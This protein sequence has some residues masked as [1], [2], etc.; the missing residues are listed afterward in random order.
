LNPIS[1]REEHGRQ[2]NQACK[3]EQ[4]EQT[5]SCMDNGKDEPPGDHASETEALAEDE[6]KIVVESREW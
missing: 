5:G 3:G 2:E 1:R 4:A 6:A